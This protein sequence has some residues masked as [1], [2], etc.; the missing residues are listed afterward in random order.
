MTQKISFAVFSF[1]LLLA[2]S[3]VLADT[4]AANIKRDRT[5][6]YRRGV[7]LGICVDQVLTQQGI[8]FKLPFAGQAYTIDE[9]TKAAVVAAT[10][11]CRVTLKGSVTGGSSGT[12]SSALNA[13][14]LR[15][16]LMAANFADS[17]SS[18]TDISGS[19]TAAAAVEPAT[20][21]PIS[22]KPSAALSGSAEDPL[23]LPTDLSQVQ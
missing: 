8:T 20:I 10:S 13:D 15:A 7:I 2:S 5:K 12:S 11:Q 9:T 23:S 17:N 14:T 18:A 1:L 19:S 22:V 16:N 3:D 6:A 21:A 4:T